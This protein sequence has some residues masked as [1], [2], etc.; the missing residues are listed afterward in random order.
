MIMIIE[1]LDYLKLLKMTKKGDN[2]TLFVSF[3][4]GIIILALVIWFMVNTSK[5]SGGVIDGGRSIFDRLLGR[6]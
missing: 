5:D 1:L 2:L 6:K 4:V 3:A